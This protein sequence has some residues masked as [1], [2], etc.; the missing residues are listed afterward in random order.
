MKKPKQTE[1]QFQSAIIELAH[2]TGWLVHHTRCVRTPRGYQT[3]IQG[4]VGFPD[5]VLAKGG[6]V[7][8][9]ELKTDTGKTSQAQRDW[10]FASGA[11]LWRPGDWPLI[12]A[13]LT[14]KG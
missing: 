1:A 4:D 6:R 11:E 14:G 5:L 12:E 8:L 7:I 9:A 3:P 2:A 10:M 13:V